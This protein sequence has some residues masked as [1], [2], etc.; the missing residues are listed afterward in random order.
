MGRANVGPRWLNIDACWEPRSANTAP[1]S[2]RWVP[3]GL[4]PR[5]QVHHNYGTNYANKNNNNNNDTATTT[6]TT[7]TTPTIPTTGATVPPPSPEVGPWPA[8]GRKPINSNAITRP[9]SVFF[10]RSQVRNDLFHG[11]SNSAMVRSCGAIWQ[12]W[13]HSRS[14]VFCTWRSIQPWD[15][16]IQDEPTRATTDQLCPAHHVG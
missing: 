9:K 7:A 1:R 2:P 12:R 11:V 15:R 5:R 13:S 10:A 16:A 6:T 3:R 14:N 8:V 4:R